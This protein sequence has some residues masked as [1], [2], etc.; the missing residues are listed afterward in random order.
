[1]IYTLVFEVVNFAVYTVP[2]LCNDYD[3]CFK[4]P[5]TCAHS[6]E[7]VVLTVTISVT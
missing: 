7:L 2:Q 1:M 3:W 6:L 4:T 5:Q